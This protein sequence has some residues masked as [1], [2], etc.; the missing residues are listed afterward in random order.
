MADM[1]DRTNKQTS[2]T[3]F[4]ERVMGRWHQ[5]PMTTTVQRA[6]RV[7]DSAGNTPLTR[8]TATEGFIQRVTQPKSDIG[9]WKPR[10]TTKQAA[11]EGFTDAL[12]QRFPDIS[13]K[14]VARTEESAPTGQS[15]LVH[16]GS[17][18]STTSS[19]SDSELLNTEQPF[20]GSSDSET[21]D[22]NKLPSIPAD[23]MARHK[24]A[25]QRRVESSGSSTSTSP[26]A[27]QRKSAPANP[28][29]VRPRSKVEYFGRK[30]E[31]GTQV[32]PASAI[33]SPSTPES[34]SVTPIQAKVEEPTI[35]ET[36]PLE[37]PKWRTR[38]R[39]GFQTIPTRS[40][41]DGGSTSSIPYT[42]IQAQKSEAVST[43]IS[44]AQ[45]TT[46]ETTSDTP[47]AVV[48][49]TV[50]P[51]SPK[52][53]QRENGNESDDDLSPPSNQTPPDEPPPPPPTSLPPSTP[54]QLSAMSE[55]SERS[56][57]M[58]LRANPKPAS[59][60][61]N[62][63]ESVESL[64]THDGSI[65]PSLT[66]G[67][68]AKAVRRTSQA[69]PI[70]RKPILPSAKSQP[71]A[72]SSG[73][74]VS[75]IG[76][77]TQRSNEQPSPNSRSEELS[78]V[79]TVQRQSDVFS[80]VQRK[81][82][83][84]PTSPSESDQTST[85]AKSLYEDEGV[86]VSSDTDSP[87]PLLSPIISQ[88]PDTSVALQRQVAPEANA[89]VTAEPNPTAPVFPEQ[90][91]MPLRTV[92]GGAS[93]I[94]RQVNAES[95]DGNDPKHHGR[96]SESHATSV[97]EPLQRR[98]AEATSIP[99]T[100]VSQQ[101]SPAIGSENSVQSQST[102]S[103]TETP[104]TATRSNP[105]SATKESIPVQRKTEDTPSLQQ[106]NAESAERA[107]V[108]P[109]SPSAPLPSWDEMPLRVVETAS[110]VSDATVQ[111]QGDETLPSSP[112]PENSKGGTASSETLQRVASETGA[113]IL[114][115]PVDTNAMAAV[116]S[117]G[118]ASQPPVEPHIPVETPTIQPTKNP[119]VSAPVAV[120]STEDAPLQRVVAEPASS[121]IPTRVDMPLRTEKESGSTSATLIQRT[122]NEPFIDSATDIA[123][124]SESVVSTPP[125]PFTQP[126]VVQKVAE[127]DNTSAI[128]PNTVEPRQANT[129]VQRVAQGKPEQ[130]PETIQQVTA[131]FTPTSPIPPTATEMPLR[132]GDVGSH[133]PVQRQE[134]GFIAEASNQETAPS[135]PDSGRSAT[136]S[137]SN[138][139]LEVESTSDSAPVQR[140]AT[141]TIS[142]PTEPLQR[143]EAEIAS[144]TVP[145]REEMPLRRE[146]P[147]LPAVQRY[148]ADKAER[149][150]LIESALPSDGVAPSAPSPR[151]SAS[152]PIQRSALPAMRV[153]ESSIESLN[154]SSVTATPSIEQ[155]NRQATTL[156][157]QR[158][159]A[160]NS[161]S[162][163]E[164]VSGTG[165]NTPTQS[166]PI[167]R[168]SGEISPTQSVRP[169]VAEMPLR[170]AEN[171]N[172]PLQRE[173]NAG[174]ATE[175]I[176]ATPE[177]PLLTDGISEVDG[178]L[179]I[180]QVAQKPADT[181]EGVNSLATYS[182]TEESQPSSVRTPILPND[183]DPVQ[184]V[185]AEQELPISTPPT[186]EDMPLRTS[187][188][189]ASTL[190]SNQ[191]PVAPE[192]SISLDTLGL[193]NPA[194]LQRV[195][196]SDTPLL[197]RQDKTPSSPIEKIAPYSP[198]STQRVVSTP[199]ENTNSE[200][201]PAT[202]VPVQRVTLETST[203][204]GSILQRADMPLRDK[205][206]STDSSTIPATGMPVQ[207]VAV[208]TSPSEISV[209]QQT[210]MPSREITTGTDTSTPSA[211]DAPMQRVAVEAS[212]SEISVPQRTDMPLRE[213]TTGTESP[214][215][216]AADAPLQR[217]AVEAS[218]SEISVPQRAGMPLREIT[219]GTENLNPSSADAPMQRVT[220]E[221]SPPKGSIPQ[222][223]DMP[224]RDRIPSTDSPVVHVTGASIQKVV[225][226]PSSAEVA[227]PQRAD[228]PLREITTG[229]D[230]PTPSTADASL[231]RV[232]YEVSPPEGFIPQE[233]DMPLRDGT[234]TIQ[235][236]PANGDIS[237]SM[238]DDD[239]KAELKSTTAPSIPTVTNV[240]QLSGTP[241]SP[242]YPV[243]RK[244]TVKATRIQRKKN[245]T[246]QTQSLPIAVPRSPLQRMEATP[247]FTNPTLTAL[248]LVHYAETEAEVEPESGV[249]MGMP[250]QRVGTGNK[251]EF[252][253]Q[254]QKTL[255]APHVLPSTDT[256]VLRY[257]SSASKE[258]TPFPTSSKPAMQ[259]KENGEGDMPLVQRV[260]DEVVTPEE[261][262]EEVYIDLS[263]LFKENDEA[264][265]NETGEPAKAI[266]SATQKEPSESDALKALQT[267]ASE[268]YPL[269]KQMIARDRERH[270]GF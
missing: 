61:K 242:A 16:S 121:D 167:Q 259:T 125:S 63:V 264:G 78:S 240:Q 29:L 6:M 231:Q 260:R 263:H 187:G 11:I 177:S 182:T 138:S 217:V 235:R 140:S 120:Q 53:I 204:E 20:V 207:R 168:I 203:P 39:A 227:T 36:T 96:E 72:S 35:Q 160:E 238:G 69:A 49:R 199:S 24:E 122:A 90:D 224:L 126:A 195:E 248:P 258:N 184:R 241:S 112:A 110:P 80:S 12:I 105:P 230:N 27:V 234:P 193:A 30:T 154:T 166:T 109:I 117:S 14:Y 247:R 31:P 128:P 170:I 237:T 152:D 86:Q 32:P 19:S 142:L 174:M 65:L 60:T 161:D 131:K 87:T 15:N 48:Q 4:A 163:S 147:S 124:T 201:I 253:M 100:I 33:P 57:E 46:P 116:K 155:G 92:E 132:Q 212:A 3:T 145:L 165:N 104:G 59:D 91:T 52:P 146:N 56:V 136:P 186:Q 244:A 17:S 37:E 28:Q 229:T 255:P 196:Q 123:P 18:T 70:L 164:T 111:R 256:Q 214:T 93:P 223:A 130:S 88:S 85:G 208:E 44:E 219:T 55:D 113:A 245:P 89:R 114:Q 42:P 106:V 64:D 47:T 94:Q 169:M 176:S 243:Q 22:V 51:T 236:Q 157:I 143:V 144:P 249:E 269:L 228:I 141:P 206:P 158:E 222:Q 200:T 95:A 103:T 221:A 115:T 267:L 232:T 133:A 73:S 82:E 66:R 213:I 151:F 265:P 99:S 148:P 76:Q 9:V 13:A 252:P 108:I 25:L 74:Q 183:K 178:S 191:N 266:G 175:G 226:E 159:S 197:N 139:S 150:S 135:S 180:Q 270:R 268:I 1:S 84:Q 190:P 257:R 50:T 172:T 107:S 156:P 149:D 8:A 261:E 192:Q 54:L 250:I 189:S 98:T 262:Q 246:S 81:V 68:P 129:P 218:A 162:F 58:P 62:V 45:L 34:S 239:F 251:P 118:S 233:V 10:A 77:P 26:R 97:D 119:M 254:R 79:A 216:S 198:P 205:T 83:L 194:P 23:V 211:T 179:P 38:P 67:I 102:V 185:H 41:A 40:A 71:I 43:E 225:D 5:T 220:V 209:P 21:F 181:T 188:P 2:L 153:E 75:P 202:D 173:S 127:S 215:P 7:T 137:T 171:T 210:N 134:D 101:D